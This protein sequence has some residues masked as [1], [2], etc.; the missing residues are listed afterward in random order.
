MRLEQA[1]EAVIYTLNISEHDLTDAKNKHPIC[2][3]G[4]E[5]VVDLAH[6]PEC[7][8][9]RIARRLWGAG[10]ASAITAHQRFRRKL[11]GREPVVYWNGVLINASGLLELV[12][13]SVSMPGVVCTDRSKTVAA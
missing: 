7:S 10:H 13:A 1:I 12:R 4:R 2:V 9:P 3:L 5:L 8:Y 6:G 11:R